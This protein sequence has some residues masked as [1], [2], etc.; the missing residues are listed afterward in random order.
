MSPHQS[1][2]GEA[3]HSAGNAERD[4][5]VSI[6]ANMSAHSKKRVRITEF[7]SA[8]WEAPTSGEEV[9]NPKEN[10]TTSATVPSLEE[11]ESLTVSDSSTCSTCVLRFKDFQEQRQHFSSDLHRYNARFRISRQLPPL[12][13]EEFE[14]LVEANALDTASQESLSGSETES[15][16]E[17]ENDGSKDQDR[18]NTGPLSSTGIALTSSV[19]LEFNHPTEPGKFI[20]MHKTAL[21]DE[22]SLASL[23]D[24]GPWAV[25]MSGGGHF[26]G[27]VWNKDGVMTHHKTFHRYTSRKK[28]GGSQAVADSAGG[29]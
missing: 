28:Q 5:S 6:P 13:E 10:E 26:A 20:V 3:V 25:F 4:P 15:D 19:K 23:K 7:A 29:R 27:A 16:F 24:R 22:K 12:S 17:D 8:T 21:P 18:G 2:S 14:R 9:S 11:L 1:S